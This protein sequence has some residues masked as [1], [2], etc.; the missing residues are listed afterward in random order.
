MK[1]TP[2]KLKAL[3]TDGKHTNSTK[4]SITVTTPLAEDEC[5]RI[6]A[7]AKITEASCH[8]SQYHPVTMIIALRQ[9]P[10]N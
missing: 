5:R 9:Q 2:R 10:G 4:H 6:L 7:E 1:L 3:F 8:R